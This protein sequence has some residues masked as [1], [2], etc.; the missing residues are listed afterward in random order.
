MHAHFWN[1]TCKVI[2]H[3]HNDGH[4]LLITVVRV[5]TVGRVELAQA[6]KRNALKVPGYSTSA[7]NVDYR[8]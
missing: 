4:T 3:S 1:R 7:G 6:F 2:D 8:Q 5:Q